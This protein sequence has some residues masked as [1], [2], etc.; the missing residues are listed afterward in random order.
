VASTSATMAFRADGSCGGLV[1]G[2]TLVCKE[3][4]T[5]PYNPNAFAPAVVEAS[6]TGL[7]ARYVHRTV[8]ASPDPH[9][10]PIPGAHCVVASGSVP[11]GFRIICDKARRPLLGKGFE[12]RWPAFDC[13]PRNRMFARSFTWAVFSAVRD[14]SRQVDGGIF[15]FALPDPLFGKRR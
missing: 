4:R 15:A 3:N 2:A 8:L 5:A 12:L 7:V 9:Q 11:A 6:S 1:P 13:D 14:S 10:A